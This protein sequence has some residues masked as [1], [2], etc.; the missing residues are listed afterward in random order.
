VRYKKASCTVRSH[1]PLRPLPNSV[2]HHL[3]YFFAMRSNFTID[4]HTHP[5]P[6]FYREA[7]ISAG[8][9]TTEG[10]ELFVDGFRM[11]NFTIESYVENRATFGYDFSIMSITA[12]GVSLLK[13][14]SQAASLARRLN[15]QMFEWTKKYPASLGAFCILP[16]PDIKSSIEE[17]RV[18]KFS[19]HPSSNVKYL[20]NVL[21][22]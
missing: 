20:P 4:V 11:P 16:L 13:G 10:G 19:T 6:G 21:L 2:R 18:S 1:K 8:Y 14:N 12:P 22:S 15:Q 3:R 17:I 7:I 5:I 9:N